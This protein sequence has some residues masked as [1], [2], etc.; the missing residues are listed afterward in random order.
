[1]WGILAQVLGRFVPE[2][3]NIID[4]SFSL[5]A[6]KRLENLF[7]SAGFRDIRVA[8]HESKDVVESFREYWEPIEAGTGSLP[9]I[10]LALSDVDRRSVRAEVRERLCQFKA[11]GR[12]IMNVE[13]LIGTG[14]A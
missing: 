1:M 14:R 2:Q 9:Q 13:M 12:L 7:A 10:Y 11:R 4:L 5:A 8:R 3:K 6:P